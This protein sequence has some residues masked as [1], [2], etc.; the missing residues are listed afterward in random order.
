MNKFCALVC[1]ALFSIM[2]LLFNH[3]VRILIVCYF[4][5]LNCNQWCIDQYLNWISR[6]KKFWMV[7]F[8]NFQDLNT[9]KLENFQLVTVHMSFWKIPKS[10]IV[11]SVTQHEIAPT[12]T[13]H[14]PRYEQPDFLIKSTRREH[15]CWFYICIV[16]ATAPM[17]ILIQI[18]GWTHIFIA[19]I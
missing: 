16:M 11:S 10:C 15:A 18:F 13:G 17:N 8:A 12:P 14:P 19:P 5:F 7:A 6:K 4:S 3:V 2:L 9:L 1:P